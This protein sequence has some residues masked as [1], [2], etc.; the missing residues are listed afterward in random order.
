MSDYEFTMS[1]RVRH[2]QVEPAEVTRALGMEPQH[3]WR[4]GEQRRDA[5]GGA[6]GGTYQESLWMCALMAHPELATDSVGVESELLH[7][8]NTLRRSLDFLQSLRASGGVTEL[9]ISIFA[10][11]EF[12]L[13]LPADSLVVLGQMGITMALE[14]NPHSS[15]MAQQPVHQ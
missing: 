14:V 7:A 2:P 10:R 1:L 9:H 8:I 6:L 5:G 4:A 3:S 11:Q 15:P 13:E 12:R